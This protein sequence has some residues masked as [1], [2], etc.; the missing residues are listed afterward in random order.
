MK[1]TPGPPARPENRVEALQQQRLLD[2]E[3]TRARSLADSWRTGVAGL[4]AGIIGFSLI[5]GRTEID[6]LA[7]G[8]A[9]AVGVVLAVSIATG[10]AAAFLILRAAHGLP[11]AVPAL[12]GRRSDG[13]VAKYVTEHDEAMLTLSALRAGLYLAAIATVALLVAV[14]LTWYGPSEAKPGVVITEKSG[15]SWCGQ[16]EQTSQGRLTLNTLSGRVTVDLLSVVSILPVDS[17]PARP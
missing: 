14:G 17:C 13:K 15:A 5:R 10:A 12:T 7:T 3:L 16:V 4:L 11:V 1:L 2:D 8:Y 9:V 6:K